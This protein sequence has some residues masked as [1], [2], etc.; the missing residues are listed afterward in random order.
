LKTIKDKTYKLVSNPVFCYNIDVFFNREKV[1]TLEK[2]SFECEINPHITIDIEANSLEENP[3]SIAAKIDGKICY[4]S[5]DNAD[6]LAKNMS[7]LSKMLREEATKNDIANPEHWGDYL[8]EAKYQNVSTSRLM[9][10]GDVWLVDHDAIRD[11]IND[12]TF[13]IYSQM[14]DKL[15]QMESNHLIHKE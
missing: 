3:T 9:I 5:L 10:N 7:E 13:D 2:T 11:F 15:D 4:L 1:M 6:K 12:Y 14:F 8:L